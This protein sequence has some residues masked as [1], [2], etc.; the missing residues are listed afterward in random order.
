MS[1][2]SKGWIGVDLDGTLA[3]YDGWKGTHHIGAPIK[4][5]VRRVKRWIAAGREVRIFTARVDE[6]YNN[7]A[8]ARQVIMCWGVSVLGH[9]LPV[10]NVK[11]AD[12]LELYDDRAVQVEKNT[13]RLIG[14]ST[15][16]TR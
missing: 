1:G 9:I 2:K 7:V 10:T 11:D 8:I 12:M 5:M 15:R 4:P 6:R 3:H 16:R 13:G 14:R